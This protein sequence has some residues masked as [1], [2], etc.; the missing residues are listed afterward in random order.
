MND[1]CFRNF[2]QKREPKFDR[3]GER[4]QKF[5][6]SKRRRR[7][8]RNEFEPHFIIVRKRVE[9]PRSL[10]RLPAEILKRRRDERDFYFLLKRF[11]FTL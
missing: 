3:S 6:I 10:D 7:I 2:A 5:Y 1:V 4:A 8:V 9:Q 11:E